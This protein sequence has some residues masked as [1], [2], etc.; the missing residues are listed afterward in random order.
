[1]IKRLMLGV[2]LVALPV[3]A[4]G[5]SAKAPP[6]ALKD[7][8]GR[9]IRLSDYR[10]KIVLLNFWAAWCPPCRAE[11]PGFVKWQLEYRRKGLQVVGVTYPPTDLTE[12]RKFVRSLKV[13]YPILLGAKETKSLFDPGENLPLTVVID[14]E[15]NVRGVI[16]G[17]ILPQEFEQKV[18]PLLIKEV[19]SKPLETLHSSTKTP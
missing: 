15:G 18:K 12:V 11:M 1:M 9:T 6:V 2:L 14:R 5:Q 4:A 19:A 8:R 17:I 16:K 3:A 7:L 13:N 10:G